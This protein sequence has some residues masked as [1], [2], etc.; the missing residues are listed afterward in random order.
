MTLFPQSQRIRNQATVA[1][2]GNSRYQLAPAQTQSKTCEE[3]QI[4][5]EL[6]SQ[7]LAFR[8]AGNPAT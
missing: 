6:T 2:D 8:E 7:L 1:E 4:A 3:R 5:T